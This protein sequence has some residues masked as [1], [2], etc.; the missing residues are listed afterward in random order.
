M[1]LA[2]KAWLAANGADA[3][4]HGYQWKD[5]FLLNGTEL[6]LRYQ[7]HYYNARISDDELL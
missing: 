2:I 3:D 1:N 6:R 7:G 5:L 4:R